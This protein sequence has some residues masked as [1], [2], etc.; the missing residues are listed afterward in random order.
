[1]GCGCQGGNTAQQEFHYVSPKGVK[2]VYSKEIEARV[3]QI[4]NGGGTITPVAKR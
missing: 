3:A 2:K 4:K 1:M